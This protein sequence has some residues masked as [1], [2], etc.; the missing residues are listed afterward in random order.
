MRRAGTC[1]TPAKHARQ[2]SMGA[3][4]AASSVPKT[5]TPQPQATTSQT[6]SGRQGTR[7]P[8]AGRAWRALLASTSR[9][10]VQHSVRRVHRSRPPS[11]WAGRRNVRGVRRGHVQID[12]RITRMHPLLRQ[13]KPHTDSSD[14]CVRLSVQ[15]GYT[16][17]E[18]CSGCDAGKY[19]VTPGADACTSCPVNSESLASSVGPQDCLCVAGYEVLVYDQTTK[20][21]VCNAGPLGKYKSESDNFACMP[22]QNHSST[23]STGSTDI[24]DCL[25][26]AGYQPQA[27]QCSACPAGTYKADWDNIACSDCP[28]NSFSMPASTL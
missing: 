10:L 17:A 18:A 25:C 6:A 26:N 5:A 12:T 11:D 2:G 7:A 8:T 21:L 4:A 1:Q 19:K 23:I 24:G 14:S 16:V 20:A 27:S 28:Q 3:R 13:F 9:H 15:H 22:C